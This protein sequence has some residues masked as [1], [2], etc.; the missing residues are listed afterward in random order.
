MKINGDPSPSVTGLQHMAAKARESR[1]PAGP[2]EP[3]TGQVATPPTE[4]SA[5]SVTPPGG[6][7]VSATGKNLPPAAA[8]AQSAQGPDHVTGL[9]RAIEQLQQN[10]AKSPQ[11][12]GLQHA[13]EMLQRNQARGSTVDTSA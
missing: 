1:K 9:D 13:L 7:N 4:N 2:G 5:A 10:A 12:T 6:K 11:A 8:A 3:G